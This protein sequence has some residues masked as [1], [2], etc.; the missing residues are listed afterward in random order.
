M[1]EPQAE[2]KSL[3]LEALTPAELSEDAIAIYGEDLTARDYVQKLSERGL[4]PDAVKYLAHTLH[5][6]FYIEWSLSCVRS[7]QLKHTAAEQESLAAAEKWL[8]DPTDPN[9]RAAQAAAEKAEL[10]TAA[11]CVGMAVFF[12]EGSIAPP[13]RDPVPA[14][15]HVAKKIA[16]GAIILAVAKEPEKA[17]ERYKSCLQLAFAR[18]A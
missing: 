16:A 9:R 10:T 2:L 12:C 7:L 17:V 6:H 15:P 8:A 4:F 5:G 3:P 14:P 11:G 18:A 13:E 1:A